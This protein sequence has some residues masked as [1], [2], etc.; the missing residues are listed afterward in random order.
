MRIA[1][2]TLVALFVTAS[3]IPAVAEKASSQS[4]CRPRLMMSVPPGLRRYVKTPRV[5][6]QCQ[7]PSRLHERSLPTCNSGPSMTC[8]GTCNSGRPGSTWITWQCCIDRSGFPPRCEL[9]CISG[10]AGCGGGI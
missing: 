9:N 3:V 8:R 10:V 2:L 4:A 5:V 1:N 7:S 6:G